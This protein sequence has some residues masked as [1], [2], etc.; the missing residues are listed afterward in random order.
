MWLGLMGYNFF[1]LQIILE[2]YL[3]VTEKNLLLVVV[4]TRFG[5]RQ[6]LLKKALS[7]FWVK[8]NLLRLS[9]FL[10]CFT[11]NSVSVHWSWSLYCEATHHSFSLARSSDV[12][13]SSG[14]TFFIFGKAGRGCVGDSSDSDSAS[15]PSPP[16]C[17]KS[18]KSSS[19]WR[20]GTPF[21]VREE[22]RICHSTQHVGSLV[23]LVLARA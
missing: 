9:S 2:Y 16:E 4:G 15:E 6:R 18:E 12:N 8:S 3:Q 10:R 1:A 20:G 23:R 11:S 19:M 14:Y 17:S 22:I 21:V 7:C 5:A 13:R